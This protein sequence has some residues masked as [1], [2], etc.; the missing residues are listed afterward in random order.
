MLDTLLNPAMVVL[1]GLV[2]FFG[3]EWLVEGA[4]GVAGRFGIKKIVIGLTVVAYGTSAP[5]LAVSISANIGG[6]APLL[7]GNVIGS[8]IANMALILGITALISP[9]PVGAGLMRRDLPVLLF[10]AGILPVMLI[11]GGV[12]Q[13]EAAFLASCAVGYTLLTLKSAGQTISMSQEGQRLASAGSPEPANDNGKTTMALFLLVAVGL[14]LL[15]GG[16]ELFVRGAKGV[17]LDLGMSE[18][19]VG[20]TIVAFGTSVPEL[21]TSLTAARKGE[22][23][24]AI[25]G[26]IGSNIFNIFLV[27][28][29]SGTIRALPGDFTSQALDFGF[30]GGITLFGVFA[31]RTARTVSRIEGGILVAAYVTFILLTTLS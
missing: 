1:G 30:L 19:T 10:S 15:I 29:V 12:S 11:S 3:A 17:A 18:R 22:T 5:E 8:C 14:G 20:L 28:G 21:A 16:G 31:M 9:V 25:G 7:F 27:V 4:A 13:I 6:T 26:I 2:L 24:L 23:E